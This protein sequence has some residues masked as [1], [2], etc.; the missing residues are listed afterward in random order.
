MRPAAKNGHIGLAI[1]LLSV[2][3][4]RCGR[5]IPSPHLFSGYRSR[6]L[7]VGRRTNGRGK[8]LS[9]ERHVCGGGC[10]MW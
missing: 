4:S 10:G 2:L 9:E 6:G 1:G 3:L 8:L 5:H 7:G